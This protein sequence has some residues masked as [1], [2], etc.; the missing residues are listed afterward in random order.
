MFVKFDIQK[1][2]LLF[3]H[4][5]LTQDADFARLKMDFGWR[6]VKF[7]IDYF[8]QGSP[9]SGNEPHSRLRLAYENAIDWFPDEN[10]F[11]YKNDAKY[12]RLDNKDCYAN[13]NIF[14]RCGEKINKIFHVPELENFNALSKKEQEYQYSLSYVDIRE[15]VESDDDE[16]V[17]RR[18]ELVRSLAQNLAAVTKLREDSELQLQERLSQVKIA[19]LDTFM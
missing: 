2:Q 17:K 1:N 15:A 14:V 8:W 18:S 19:S 6:G 13:I 16:V 4:E 7:C 3:N 12:L 9:Y 10:R 5:Q 11:G